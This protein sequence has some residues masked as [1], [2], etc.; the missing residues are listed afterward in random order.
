[1]VDLV[2]NF[3][4][5]RGITLQSVTEKGEDRLFNKLEKTQKIA[6]I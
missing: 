1:M 2:T 3:N 5:C 4:D 6:K